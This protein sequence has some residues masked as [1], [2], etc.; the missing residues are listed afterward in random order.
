MVTATQS[1]RSR[2]QKIGQTLTRV[3]GAAPW[4]WPIL[5]PAISRFF[6]D[7]AS[8]WDRRTG[9]GSPEHL[10]ALAAAVLHL[11]AV[12]ERVL[13]LGCGT[14]SGSLF[15]TREFPRARVRGVDI[16]PEM[17]HEAT[18]KVGLDPEGRI[19]FRVA[20]AASLPFDDD[21]FDLVTQV[22]VP[23]FLSELT[24]VVRPGGHVVICA[25]RGPET[26]FYTPEHVL[27]NRLVRRNVE[28][29]KIGASGRGTYYVGR[30]L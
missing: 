28:T 18:R 7:H 26:P 6:S 25:S 22:N 9:A 27:E 23:P 15:L 12:P 24:R 14:G 16:S 10:E 17:I 3:I 20:D 2:E 4:T 8:E 21:S 30:A 19:A 5:R 13:D 11:G 1:K 29:V